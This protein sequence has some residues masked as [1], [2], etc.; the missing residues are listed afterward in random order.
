MAAPAALE[1]ILQPSRGR[2]D[3]PLTPGRRHSVLRRAVP[4]CQGSTPQMRCGCSV[5]LRRRAASVCVICSGSRAP[6]PTLRS[7]PT[8]RPRPRSVRPHGD[9]VMEDFE[10][11]VGQF[12]RPHL[13][14]REEVLD[15]VSRSCFGR[16]L[17]L[18]VPSAARTTRRCRLRQHG[19]LHAA[20][21]RHQPQETTGE[22]QATQSPAPLQPHLNAGMRAL[23]V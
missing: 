10:H 23:R 22:R 21:D 20:V 6:E 1:L 9:V 18:V 19:W 16:C 14:T 2:A 13:L 8:E 17:R 12:L 15:P 3:H 11:P 4:H 7:P 5:R